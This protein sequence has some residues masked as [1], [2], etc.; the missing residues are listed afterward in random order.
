MADVREGDGLERA[1][2]GAHVEDPWNLR[3]AASQD[4]EDERSARGGGRFVGEMVVAAEQARFLAGSSGLMFLSTR[5]RLVPTVP[6]NRP[7]PY[8][9]GFLVE[10][11]ANSS[12][13]NSLYIRGKLKL[14]PYIR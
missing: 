11:S 5:L 12:H 10:I 1:R 4:C 2:H 14:L 3:M 7:P 8:L 9:G 6:G 13:Q